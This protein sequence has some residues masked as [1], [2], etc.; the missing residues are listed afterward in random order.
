MKPYK[1]KSPGDTI[2]HIR[3]ILHDLGI[4]TTEQH[5]RREGMYYSC[6]VFIDNDDI[7]RFDIGTNGKG[8]NAEY[9][10]ASA[11]A[12][13]LERLENR[14]LVMAV[15]YAT[16]LFYQHNP[17]LKEAGYLPFRYF[18]DETFTEITP[19]ELWLDLQKLL[20]NVAKYG[21]E[22]VEGIDNY[23]MYYADFFNAMT[24]VTEHLPYHLIRFAASS[25]GLCAG[26]E[27]EEA[28]LQGV[29]EIFERYVLQQIFLQ[30]LTPPTIPL[31]M[32]A[33]TEIY[34]RLLRLKAEKG[35]NIVIKDCSLGKG[36]PVI[37]LLLIDEEAN[38]YAFRLGADLS[39]VIALQRCFT[40]AF[41]GADSSETCLQPIRLDEDW[42]IR[43]EHNNNVVNG[44]GRFPRELF[45]TIG[46]WEFKD[47]ALEE[48]SSQ[49]EDLFY[50]KH[51]L[52]K[53]NYTLYVRDNSFLNFPAYHVFIPGLSEVDAKLYDVITDL[54]E[55][56]SHFFDVKM[57][58][59]LQ[60]LDQREKVLF[61]EKYKDANTDTIKLFPYNASSNNIVNRQLI[62]ALMC[63]SLGRDIEAYSHMGEFLREKESAGIHLEAYYYCIRDMFCAKS[64][65][66]NEEEIVRS[67]AVIYSEELVREVLSDMKDRLGVLTN[68]SFPTCFYCKKCPSWNKGCSYF[69]II[70]LEQ[71]IQKAQTENVIKQS[72]LNNVFSQKTTNK[73][74]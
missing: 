73:M 11:Y 65:G 22:Q 35:W 21:K 47:F 58:Y 29:N 63:Y 59:R 55:D 25:T 50:I 20:P 48:Q 67:L 17:E 14:M 49:K 36:F 23:K 6:R 9:A 46:S 60:N 1:A 71:K 53:N 66:K 44:R 27:P 52:E 12:E 61:I 38:R 5:M 2:H 19:D 43:I 28:I 3:S 62:L 64:V 4:F 30:R 24:G 34:N 18:P 31:E 33:G 39:P 32:F 15:K 16:P 13:L 8:M 56:S 37:G 74:Q 42:D 45:Y 51:W 72:R 54:K 57:E 69:T 26:N 10:L 40:E 7:R 70:R 68:F 41:Q